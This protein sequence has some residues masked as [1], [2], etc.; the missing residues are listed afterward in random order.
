MTDNTTT[1][2]LATA[3]ELPQMRALLAH[4]GLPTADLTPRHLSHFLVCRSGGE[5]AG[6]IGIEPFGD[7]GLLRSL[8]VVPRFRGQGLAGRLWSHA[9]EHAAA[10]GLA[11]LYLL[12][13]TSEAI[14]ARWGF[15]SIERAAAPA[16]VLSTPQ[17]ASLCPSSALL[18]VADLSKPRPS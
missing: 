13:D 9:R 18:M 15:R 16:A 4:S 12:T 11:Q 14:F 17:L 6:M 2:G 5:L 7:V 1:F 8:C 3:D 10:C